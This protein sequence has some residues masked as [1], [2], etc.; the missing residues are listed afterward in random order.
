MATDNPLSTYKSVC[1]KPAVSGRQVLVAPTHTWVSPL[2]QLPAST[3]VPGCSHC[4]ETNIITHTAD[5]HCMFT[6]ASFPGSLLVL[7]LG[8]SLQTSLWMSC[9]WLYTSE[10]KSTQIY[11]HEINNSCLPVYFLFIALANP[12]LNVFMHRLAFSLQ[13]RKD[14]SW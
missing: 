11:S 8:E 7:F 12:L 14:E 13:E 1:S 4:M 10:G 2:S 9:N 3:L 6:L 5:A